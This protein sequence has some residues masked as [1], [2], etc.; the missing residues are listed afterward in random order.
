MSKGKV[1]QQS[2]RARD[3]RKAR[4]KAIEHARAANESRRRRVLEE[5]GPQGMACARK[6]RYQTRDEA[7]RYAAR[8]ELRR[9]VILR[10]YRCPRCGGW[11]LTHQPRKGGE[12]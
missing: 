8:Y 11:H 9:D 12:R 5:Y 3:F 10:T 4:K 6:V 7:E 1:P 2:K